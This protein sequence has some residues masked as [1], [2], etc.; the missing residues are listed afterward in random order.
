[1]QWWDWIVIGLYI[2]AATGTALYFSRRASQSTE[3]FFIAGRSLPWYIAGTSLAAAT[4]SA[5][6]PLWVAALSRKEG[7]FANWFW[8]AMGIGTISTVF[9]FARLWRRT[10]AVTDIEFITLRYPA[11]PA[12]SIL[13]VFKVFFDGVLINCVII[14]S[15]TLAMAKIAKVMLHLSD[16][17]LLTVPFFGGLDAT[18]L[19]LVVLG[20]SIVLYTMLAGLYGVVYLDTLQ[21]ILAMVGSIA[22]AVIV[23][24]DAS[25][26]GGTGLLEKITSSAGY[27]PELLHFFPRVSALNLATFSFFTYVFMIWW[28]QAPAGYFFVQRL[29]ACKT[30]RDSLYAFLWYNFVQFAIKTWPWVLVGVL[31]LHYLPD[32]KDADTAF[33][34]MID[35]FMPAGLKGVLVASLLAA[36]ASAV[37]T[38][39]NWGSS[40]LINDFYKPFLAKNRDQKHYV[41]ASQMATLLLT[42][43]A[44]FVTTRLRTLIDAYFF[45]NLFMGGMGTVLILRWYWWRVNAYSEIS[46]IIATFVIGIAVALLLPDVARGGSI[47]ASLRHLLGL[48]DAE[49]NLFAVRLAITIVSVAV[50]WIG[51]TL[52]SSRTPSPK[53]IEF[54]TR[55]KIGGPGWKKVADAT[56]IQPIDGEFRENTI[57]WLACTV[58][59]LALML[60]I[61]YCLFHRFALGAIFLTVAVVGGAVLRR[62]MNRMKFM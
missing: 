43:V 7:I 14:A 37:N 47:P 53:T 52:I 8:W 44:L 17:I 31:S 6:T 56:G 45:I 32:L 16:E 11:S 27:H 18:T 55:M 21:F 10:E 59:I 49:M 30:E 29:L 50:V 39:L 51:V 54:Y 42:V 41:R 4:F 48:P 15:V 62:I 1:M 40:Y 57:A 3:D 35:K 28:S 12:V 5:D 24:F 2:V 33:P 25:T 22:L 20:V 26:K 34:L 23:Y 58:L 60:S 46:A 61:G 38:L 13:R 9:F 36:F 19:V